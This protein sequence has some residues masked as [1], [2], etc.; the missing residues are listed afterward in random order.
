MTFNIFR[1]GAAQACSFC[2]ITSLAMQI[3]Y[4]Q[5]ANIYTY[6]KLYHNKRPGI[7]TSYEDIRQIYLILSYLPSNLALL[8]CTDIK[9]DIDDVATATPDLYSKIC[10]NGSIGNN[11][12]NTSIANSILPNGRVLV[13]LNDDE[14]HHNNHHVENGELNTVTIKDTI[15]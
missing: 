6:A 2:I 10:S 14:E 9:S 5:T 8:K 15:Q 4:D 3:E 11:L 13:K 1:F 12:N 7:W